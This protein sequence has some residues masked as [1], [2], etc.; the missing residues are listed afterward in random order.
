MLRALLFSAML[1]TACSESPFELEAQR[2]CIAVPDPAVLQV[3][4]TAAY[5][6]WVRRCLRQ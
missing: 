1:V 3:V 2:Q 5:L 4:D 6:H